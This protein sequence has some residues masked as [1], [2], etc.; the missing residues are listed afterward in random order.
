MKKIALIFVLLWSVVLGHPAYKIENLDIIALIQKD[1]SINI[2]EK[3]LYDIGD[4]N[5][6]FYNID[7]LGYGKLENLEIFYE[8]ERGKGFERDQ[9]RTRKTGRIQTKIYKKTSSGCLYKRGTGRNEKTSIL[10]LCK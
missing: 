9:S 5:G 7:A 3:V 10:F 2:D 6:I 8:E 4:I 1:E